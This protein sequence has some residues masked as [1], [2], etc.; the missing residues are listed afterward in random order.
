MG[1]CPTC[2]PNILV[3]QSLIFLSF[4]TFTIDNKRLFLLFGKVIVIFRKLKLLLDV[5]WDPKGQPSVFWFCGFEGFV[6][7]KKQLTA[8]H[9]LR[10]I[11]ENSGKMAGCLNGSHFSRDYGRK[12]DTPSLKTPVVLTKSDLAILNMV[13]AQLGGCQTGTPIFER[14]NHPVIQMNHHSMNECYRSKVIPL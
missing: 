14:F 13:F 11:V 2:A 9:Q 7:S 6:T 10:D 5:F 3:Q 4:M 1:S 12:G 8:Q